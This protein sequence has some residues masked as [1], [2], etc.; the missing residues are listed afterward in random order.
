MFGAVGCCALCHCLEILLPSDI[1]N[2]SQFDRFADSDL[3][4]DEQETSRCTKNYPRY[5]NRRENNSDF[6][7]YSD[8]DFELPPLKTQMCPRSDEE[9]NLK[10]VVEDDTLRKTPYNGSVDSNYASDP[11][12]EPDTSLY[13]VKNEDGNFI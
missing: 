10:S 13:M 12:Y 6:E 4:K 3:E 2:I 11:F 9:T 1:L 5:L 7:T 8:D